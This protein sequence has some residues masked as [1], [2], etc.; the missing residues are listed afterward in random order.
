MSE[1]KAKNC[2]RTV[3]EGYDYCA[4]CLHIKSKY[5]PIEILSEIL[6]T[7]QRIEVG[8]YNS[9]IEARITDEQVKK[10]DKTIE[11]KLVFIPSIDIPDIDIGGG[12]E[13]DLFSSTDFSKLAESLKKME[14]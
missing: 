7:L 13:K 10:I 6:K 11:D 2:K 9:K 14:K 3:L 1:C 12:D 5:Q 4:K 8:L